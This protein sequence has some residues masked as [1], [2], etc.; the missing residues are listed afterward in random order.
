MHKIPKIVA[1]KGIFSV[2]LTINKDQ[3]ESLIPFNPYIF[4]AMLTSGQCY[5]FETLHFHW[6]RKN[7]RGS[8]HILNGVRFPMEMHIIH[9]NKN[10][11]NMEVALNNSDGLAVL[12]IF[13]QVKTVNY[14]QN[15]SLFDIKIKY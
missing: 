15:S 13:F 1:K 14:D 4:G 6:G 12:G 2:S 11:P 5:E 7:N 9:R 3:T 10:Y 8:E